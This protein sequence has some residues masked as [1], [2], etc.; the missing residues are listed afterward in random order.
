MAGKGAR[1]RAREK[2]GRIAAGLKV[3]GDIMSSDPVEVLGA[4]IGRVSSGG[5]VAVG[6]GGRVEGGVESAKEAEVLEGGTVIGDV[7]APSVIIGGAVKGD[8]E[9]GGS[10][11]IRKTAVVSGSVSSQALQADPGAVVAGKFSQS[12]AMGEMEA[13]FGETPKDTAGK[14]ARHD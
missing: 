5:K 11:A 10:V 12:M 7:S 9:A 8:V 3:K 2:T 13:I 4:V 14:A 1:G 6:K